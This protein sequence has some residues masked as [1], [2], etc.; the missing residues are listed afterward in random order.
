MY[1][2]CLF[3]IIFVRA[4]A[5]VSCKCA[6]MGLIIT[7]ETMP[8]ERGSQLLHRIT[9]FYFVL[10]GLQEYKGSLDMFSQVK[11]ISFRCMPFIMNI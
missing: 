11:T 7:Q 2:G 3:L 1:R 6:Q 5:C 10:F 8:V 9:T 4:N